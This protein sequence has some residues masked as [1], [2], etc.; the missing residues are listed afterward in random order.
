MTAKH[1]ERELYEL[2]ARW[3]STGRPLPHISSDDL[4][5]LLRGMWDHAGFVGPNNGG[6]PVASLLAPAP[7][8]HD[9]AAVIESVT[10]KRS[11]ARPLHGMLWVGVSGRA[12]TPWLSY[13]YGSASVASPRKREQARELIGAPPWPT[14]LRSSP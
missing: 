3:L 1:R 14:P 5:H 7:L 11:V 12:C 9:I 13:L 4:A 10:A 8:A 2:G 6:Y